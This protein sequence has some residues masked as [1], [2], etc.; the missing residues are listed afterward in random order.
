MIVH[1]DAGGPLEFVEDNEN[2]YIID[3]DPGKIAEKMDYLFEHK[4][5]AKRLGQN[6]RK[7]MD[8]KNLNWD[9]VID[10]LLTD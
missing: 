4:D 1:K 2:G 10:Q 8:E 5:E 3:D 6:G 7:S 9:Y